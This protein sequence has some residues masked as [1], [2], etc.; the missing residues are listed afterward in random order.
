MLR[1]TDHLNRLLLWGIDALDQ[2]STNF[3]TAH[4]EMAASPCTMQVRV[5]AFT[6]SHA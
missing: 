3:R 4:E 2:L 5:A 6:A 1:E